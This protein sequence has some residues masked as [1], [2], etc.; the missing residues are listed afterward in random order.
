LG[1]GWVLRRGVSHSEE[2]CLGESVSLFVG[3]QCHV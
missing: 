1:C 2:P 3:F